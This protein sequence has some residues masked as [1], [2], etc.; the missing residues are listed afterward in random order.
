MGAKL[1]EKIHSPKLL[2]VFLF[3]V[4]FVKTR[5]KV[6]C[7]VGHLQKKRRRQQRHWGQETVRMNKKRKIFR[8]LGR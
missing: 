3:F 5:K 1:H 4:L 6:Q 2:P 8:F 7:V